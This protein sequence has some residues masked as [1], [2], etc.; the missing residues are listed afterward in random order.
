MR[1]LTSKVENAHKASARRPTP[2]SAQQHRFDES[3]GELAK[4]EVSAA[5]ECLA[6]RLA[7]GILQCNCHLLIAIYAALG[8]HSDAQREGVRHSRSL[9]TRSVREP[10]TASILSSL[11]IHRLGSSK[12]PETS[13]RSHCTKVSSMRRARLRPPQYRRWFII[14]R[15]TKHGLPLCSERSISAGALG[16]PTQ[17]SNTA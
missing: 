3:R 5:P 13:R 8:R 11:M 10:R 6:S 9:K 16:P 17:R 12:T 7:R 2:P 15:A 1:S 14:R 4:A